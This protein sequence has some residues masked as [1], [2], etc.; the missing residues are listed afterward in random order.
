[1]Q[2]VQIS[3]GENIS[4][5]LKGLSY[6]IF[7]MKISSKRHNESYRSEFPPRRG[8]GNPT[9]G[10]TVPHTVGEISCIWFNPNRSLGLAGILAF[11]NIGF[12]LG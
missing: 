9:L 4:S 10:G 8:E 1:M 11:K 3:G 2:Y 7:Y 6:L 5:S 12:L